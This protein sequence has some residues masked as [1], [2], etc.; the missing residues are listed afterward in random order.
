MSRFVN[1]STLLSSVITV[2]IIKIQTYQSA[3]ITNK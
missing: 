1:S 2:I 3:I